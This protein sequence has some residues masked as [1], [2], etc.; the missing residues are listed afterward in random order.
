VNQKGSI[1]I[2]PVIEASGGVSD[3][4]TGRYTAQVYLWLRQ[5][6]NFSVFQQEKVCIAQTGKR[7]YH[8]LIVRDPAP[9]ITRTLEASRLI[10]LT[11]AV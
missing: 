6:L 10:L 11:A 5:L 4:T 9:G 2:K 8:T 1:A 3:Y 7:M